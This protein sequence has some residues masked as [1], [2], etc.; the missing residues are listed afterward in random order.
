MNLLAAIIIFWNTMK[1]GEVV[2]TR[3]A[4][5]TV[6]RLIYSPTSRRW[7]GNTSI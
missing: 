7:D 2:N 6:S 1:L 4:S 3:A 5:G